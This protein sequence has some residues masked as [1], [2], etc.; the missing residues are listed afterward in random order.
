MTDSRE[1][2]LARRVQSLINETDHL[3]KENQRLR[4]LCERQPTP[5]R[6][7]GI[8]TESKL[9][10]TQIHEFSKCSSSCSRDVIMLEDDDPC[11]W[12]PPFSDPR[13]PVA[14]W[15]APESL[16]T[17]LDIKVFLM[18]N[19]LPFHS[20][21]VPYFQRHGLCSTCG[22][23][24]H[25]HERCMFRSVAETYVSAAIHGS[26]VQAENAFQRYKTAIHHTQTPSEIK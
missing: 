1:A 17:P 18:R 11:L 21:W 26:A 3:R 22:L 12:A 24:G 5:S 10:Q 19:K 9:R 23:K 25:R 8:Q 15:C 14:M 16:R 4:A 13:A 20:T 6:D 2:A 7:V